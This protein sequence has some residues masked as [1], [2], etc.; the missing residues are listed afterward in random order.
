MKSGISENLARKAVE[1]GFWSPPRV[2]RQSGFVTSL[3]KEAFA[4]QVVLDGNLGQQ[5]SPIEALFYQEPVFSDFD[6]FWL[7]RL[8]RREQRHFD[9]QRSQVRGP[10]RAESGILQS[11]AYRAMSD[12]LTQ[13][14]FGLDYADAAVQTLLDVQRHKRSAFHCE[15]SVRGNLD[16]SAIAGDS[17]HHGL[18]G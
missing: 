8:E 14:I 4:I 1:S 13:R 7:D 11:C 2:S 16:E 12:G 6:V 3:P 18:A 10:H 17:F 15:D 5:Q 9:F